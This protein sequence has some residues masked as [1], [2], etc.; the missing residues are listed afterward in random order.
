MGEVKNIGERIKEERERLG[1]TQE[2]FAK[3]CG[4]G[5]TAQFNYE[6]GARR[7]ASDYLGAL[8]RLGVDSRYVM[9]GVR[10]DDGWRYA[11]AYK[12]MLLS[13]ERVLGLDEALLDPITSMWIE[14]ERAL[15]GSTGMVDMEP[16]N[17]ALLD[18]LKSG[19]LLD[20]C[21]DQKLLTA[22]IAM[23]EDAAA[24]S[25]SH[26]TPAKKSSAILMLYRS[27]K[28]GGVVDTQLVDAA[29]KLAASA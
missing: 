6:R 26:I 16:Y 25:H 21:F 28:A 23:F 1:M 17:L 3:E 9:T 11:R 4:V 13:I 5:R 29:V 20:V 8:D 14:G 27:F 22:T 7:P 2:A 12:M 19:K 18:W 10:D 24:Q 15:A